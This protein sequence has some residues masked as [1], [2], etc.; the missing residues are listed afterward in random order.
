L[1]NRLF[2]VSNQGIASARAISTDYDEVPYGPSFLL[3]SAALLAGSPVAD[4]EPPSEKTAP[5]QAI[6]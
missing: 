3:P 4:G 6:G 2:P 5:Q 1:T